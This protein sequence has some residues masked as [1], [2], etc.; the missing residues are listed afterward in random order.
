MKDMLFQFLIT[1]MGKFGRPQWFVYMDG[2]VLVEARLYNLA[3]PHD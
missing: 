2:T 3:K 1:V